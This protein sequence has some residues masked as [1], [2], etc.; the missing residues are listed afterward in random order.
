MPYD[1]FNTCHYTGASP[2]A[3]ASC[4]RELASNLG[5]ATEALIIPR[6]TH[7]ACVRIIDALPADPASLEGV[8]GLITTLPGVALVIHT[9]DCVPV[10]MADPH[11]GIIAAVHSGWRGTKADITGEALR[12]MESLGSDPADIIAAMGPC[13][14][15][16]CFE[17]GQEVAEQ[18]PEAYVSHEF[19]EKPH[20]DLP[21]I[22]RDRLT[23][24]GVKSGNISMPPACSRCDHHNYF[25]ARR[26]GVKSGRTATVI[27]RESPAG[28][29]R[30]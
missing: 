28:E 4:R 9:A 14:C 13:I 10:V 22:I 16:S 12:L 27:I 5:V 2:E 29:K 26:L 23:A 6:Q 21:A 17:T 25:S 18:F 1:G 20:I 30:R 19:G 3:I 8:D 15:Q 7:S 24:S 11:K